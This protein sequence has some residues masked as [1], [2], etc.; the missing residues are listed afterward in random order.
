LRVIAYVR[1]STGFTFTG[2]CAVFAADKR[3]ARRDPQKR[4]A[5]GALGGKASLNCRKSR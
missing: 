1:D 4:R 5:P 2:K 3:N